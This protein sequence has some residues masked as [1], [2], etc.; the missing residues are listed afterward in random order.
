MTADQEVSVKTLAKALKTLADAV[1]QVSSFTGTYTTVDPKG[2]DVELMMRRLEE[3]STALFQL[4]K[5]EEMKQ[6][7]FPCVT[8]FCCRCV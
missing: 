7:F 5:L 6:L 2:F 3:H 4:A 8:F 1:F